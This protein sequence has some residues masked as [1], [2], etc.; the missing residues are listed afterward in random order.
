M[1]HWLE[2]SLDPLLAACKPECLHFWEV[3]GIWFTGAATFSAVVVSLWLAIRQSRPQ[4]RITAQERKLISGVPAGTE[5]VNPADFPDKVVVTMA[6]TG[7]VPVKV[8]G[9]FWL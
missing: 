9:V 3:V 2:H 8:I 1:T 7:A 5:S 6:N 4:L